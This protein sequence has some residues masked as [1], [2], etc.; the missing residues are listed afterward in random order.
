MTATESALR[1]P[2]QSRAIRTRA[3]LLAA[4]GAEFSAHGYAATTAKSIAQR[5]GAATGSFY[6]YFA[7]KDA[8]LRELAAA[9]FAGIAGRTLGALT[10][11]SGGALAGNLH[12]EARVRMTAV[13]RAVTDSHRDDPGLHAVLTERRHADPELDAMTSLAEHLLVAQVASMLAEWGHAGDTEALAFVLFGMVEGAVHAHV[14]GRPM[15]TDARFFETLV[16]ALVQLALPAVTQA[17]APQP[18]RTRRSR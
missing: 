8:A 11:G 5:A 4:T 12:D 10:S 15:V 13:V 17:P 9:R 3:A 14:I 1:T 6:Q 7:D 16:G 18:R 2:T